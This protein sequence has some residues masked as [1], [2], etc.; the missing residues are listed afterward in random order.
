MK[1]FDEAR[2][3]FYSSNNSDNEEYNCKSILQER[4]LQIIESEK[5][6]NQ[7][8][9]LEILNVCLELNPREV[10]IIHH[11]WLLPIP[12]EIFNDIWTSSSLSF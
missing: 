8:C 12:T 1:Q 2:E 10:V 4:A 9:N 3:L 11:K 6:V 5:N 7:V